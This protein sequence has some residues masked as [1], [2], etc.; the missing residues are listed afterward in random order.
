MSTVGLSQE[1]SAIA[2]LAKIYPASAYK[3]L[4]QAVGVVCSRER[5]L[6]WII[7]IAGL[8]LIV[9]GS[10]ALAC[11][12]RSPTDVG[13][14]AVLDLLALLLAI[15][16]VVLI[17][18]QAAAM[19]SISLGERHVQPADALYNRRRRPSWW[20]IPTLTVACVASFL[21]ICWVIA[22]NPTGGI[23]GMYGAGIGQAAS[24]RSS[25]RAGE[26]RVGWGHFFSMAAVQV[27]PA[28]LI[29]CLTWA[30]LTRYSPLQEAA[31]LTLTLVDVLFVACCA[32]LALAPV[33]LDSF[34]RPERNFPMSLYSP[35]TAG[36]VLASRF[37]RRG[38]LR[39]YFLTGYLI[40][41]AGLSAVAW[42][43]PTF[44]LFAAQAAVSAFL[45]GLL[46]AAAV[47]RGIALWPHAMANDS[48]TDSK[49]ESKPE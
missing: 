14:I 31:I 24:T 36:K 27:V 3:P 7:T 42:C 11:D 15:T 22:R 48:K 38:S 29:V 23:S 30:R 20:R 6:G 21:L 13:V 43:E 25:R 35:K 44:S 37:L 5:W 45:L 18:R 4:D 1:S 10:T 49:T 12:T 39:I 8:L 47:R 2:E 28:V 19:S 16:A 41:V 46:I 32:A 9:T 33:P 26:P 34:G 17:N 40:L